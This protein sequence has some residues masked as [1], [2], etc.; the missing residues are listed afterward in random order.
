MGTGDAGPLRGSEGW[1]PH[2]F[3]P[4]LLPIF[5]EAYFGGQELPS[6][7]GL[8]HLGCSILLQPEKV[9]RQRPTIDEKAVVCRES[10][11]FRRQ[12]ECVLQKLKPKGRS[13]SGRPRQTPRVS[14]W[15]LATGRTEK[16]S[17]LTC[18]PGLLLSSPSPPPCPSCQVSNDPSLPLIPHV[19]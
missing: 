12:G 1:L 15:E 8:A 14:H 13:G 7:S 10:W 19:I 11:C 9:F 3:I 16:P 18:H 4:H 5:F 6:L 17:S 2:A